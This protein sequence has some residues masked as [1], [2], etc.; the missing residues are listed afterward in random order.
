MDNSNHWDMQATQ[1]YSQDRMQDQLS[2]RIYLL[3]KSNMLQDQQLSKY[4]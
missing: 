3:G 4:L 1:Y 2:H